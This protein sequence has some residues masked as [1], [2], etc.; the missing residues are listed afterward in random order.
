MLSKKRSTLIKGAG[1]PLRRR[2]D[3]TIVER[4]PLLKRTKGGVVVS[5]NGRA[6]ICCSGF[7]RR[8]SQ[9]CAHD[10]PSQHEGQTPHYRVNSARRRVVGSIRAIQ[11]EK[12]RAKS[13]ESRSG[14]R[15][16]RIRL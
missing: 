11:Q 10:Q 7:P 8:A 4:V 1:I 12:R 6:C 9:G 16:R 14:A 15:L 13:W 3:R 5:V 2:E